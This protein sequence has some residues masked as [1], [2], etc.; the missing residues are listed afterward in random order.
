MVEEARLEQTEFGTQAASE[1]WFV[2]NL[3]DAKR[4][5]HDYFGSGIALTADPADFKEI[6]VNV[7]VLQ[8]GE[9]GCY[10]HRE[11]VQEGFLVL[12]GECLLI[13]EGQERPLRTWDF[14]RALSHCSVSIQPRARRRRATGPC[15]T[16]TD[17]RKPCAA[18][19]SSHVSR[20]TRP[21]RATGRVPKRQRTRPVRRSAKHSRPE[22][23]P[24]LVRR[25]LGFGAFGGMLLVARAIRA[26]RGKADEDAFVSGIRAR[27]AGSRPGPRGAPDGTSR[28]FADL[29]IK[30]R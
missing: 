23:G 26:V 21:R 6:G 17:A 10:Y 9:P 22:G 13:V 3:G 16:I 19:T 24:G 12:S 1:G 30:S 14:F 8:P 27:T 25:A 28:Y 11:N 5:V 4:I 18:T 7:D 2:L 29:L 20:W 15:P